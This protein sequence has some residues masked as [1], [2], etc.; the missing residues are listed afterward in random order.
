MGSPQASLQVAREELLDELGPHHDLQK[1]VRPD[2][3][4]ELLPNQPAGRRRFPFSSP[5]KHKKGKEY[6]HPSLVLE[7]RHLA[8]MWREKYDMTDDWNSAHDSMLEKRN[9]LGMSWAPWPYPA[10]HKRRREESRDEE[11]GENIELDYGQHGQRPAKRRRNSWSE[12]P[13]QEDRAHSSTPL[14]QQSGERDMREYFQNKEEASFPVSSGKSN[15]RERILDDFLTYNDSSQPGQQHTTDLRTRE[16]PVETPSHATV[17]ASF[18]PAHMMRNIHR[19][20]MQTVTPAVNAR[21]V[22][23]VAPDFSF[24]SNAEIMNA[25][26]ASG[27]TLS[28]VKEFFG[29]RINADLARFYCMLESVADVDDDTA[30][31]RRKDMEGGKEELAD[32][33]G[34]PERS[35]RSKPFLSTSQPE[36]SGANTN[37]ARTKVIVSSTRPDISMSSPEPVSNMSPSERE[38]MSSPRPDINIS[39]LEDIVNAA[40][41]S[42]PAKTVLPTIQPDKGL[43]VREAQ[44]IPSA[45]ECDKS[46]A[47]TNN[48]CTKTVTSSPKSDTTGKAANSDSAHTKSSS[49]EFERNRRLAKRQAQLARKAKQ[50]EERTTQRFAP[51]QGPQRHGVKE[52]T[53]PFFYGRSL[54]R[55]GAFGR[56]PARHSSYHSRRKEV[57]EVF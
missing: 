41:N 29:C 49:A 14:R 2:S 15:T 26:P 27:T 47:D 13:T 22:D 9:K 42:D 50:V 43:H 56:D 11:S 24:P 6:G 34:D 4:G 39:S 36:G 51:N 23:L 44:P 21:L 35:R 30:R 31:I 52:T 16:Q 38:I 28:D 45:S 54:A 10:N 32:D 48:A 12:K 40:A 53:R 18:R 37:T 5:P 19:H 46:D 7:R 25:I 20:K 57:E 1:R 3:P 55:Q 33:L 17:A 8:R